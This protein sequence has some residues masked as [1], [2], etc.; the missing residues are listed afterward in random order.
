MLPYTMQ[1]SLYECNPNFIRLNCTAL[2][3][4]VRAWLVSE[5]ALMHTSL[6]ENFWEKKK[7]LIYVNALKV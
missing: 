2:Q 3:L 7:A 1:I 5:V 6:E 4:K